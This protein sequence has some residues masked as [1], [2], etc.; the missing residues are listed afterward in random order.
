MDRNEE[1]LRGMRAAEI[2]RDPLMESAFEALR[3]SLMSEFLGLAYF[4][5]V[6]VVLI[7][8]Q[9]SGP[10]PRSSPHQPQHIDGHSM[11]PAP[12]GTGHRHCRSGVG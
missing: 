9:R 8:V 3:L 10:S 4:A 1:R 2:L 5:E 7:D 6:P 12:R 11:P